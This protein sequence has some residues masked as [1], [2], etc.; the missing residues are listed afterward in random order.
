MNANWIA[1]RLLTH[2]TPPRRGTIPGSLSVSGSVILIPHPKHLPQSVD[3][4]FQASSLSCFSKLARAL[5]AIAT[6][7]HLPPVSFHQLLLLVFFP[8][9]CSYVLRLVDETVTPSSPPK[10]FLLP[11]RPI[12]Y[13][14]SMTPDAI[15]RQC[16]FT[17]TV[18]WRESCV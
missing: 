15:S 1:P 4:W 6:V 17:M 16:G 11:S 12:A 7:S 13:C 8:A 3:S 18:V 2:H 14:V 10:R 5:I 9:R